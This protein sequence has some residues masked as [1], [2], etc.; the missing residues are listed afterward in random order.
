MPANRLP[1]PEY[2]PDA[3]AKGLDGRVMLKVLVG[4]DGSV[5]DVVVEHARPEGVFDAVTV[6]AVRQWQF[7]PRVE[8][9]KAIEGWVRV[10]V[11]FRA[12]DP[13]PAANDGDAPGPAPGA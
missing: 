13:A 1:P 7:A 5:K 2:P 10:P 9:G 6:A 12:S 4:A 8:N 11:D 3:A